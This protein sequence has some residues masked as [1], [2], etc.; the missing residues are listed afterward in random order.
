GPHARVYK[1]TDGGAT[2]NML[3]GGL[4]SGVMGRTGLAISQ[5]NPDKVYAIFMDSLS[6]PGGLYKTT[7]G[8]QSWTSINVVALEDACGDFGWYFSKIRLDPTND[9]DV[10]FLAILLWR[11]PPGNN[12]WQPA[13]NSHADIHD[14]VFAPTGKRY[15][16][17]DGG[18]Y[19]NTPGQM[20]WFKSNNLP[21]TQFYRTNYNPHEPDFYFAGAQDNGIR[22]G[23]AGVYNGWSSLFSADGFRCMFHPT[24]PNTFWIE[25]QNGEIH[26]TIDG[27]ANWAFGSPCLG[28]SDRCNWDL[29]YL[30]SVHNPNRLFAGTYRVYFSDNGGGWGPISNDLTDGV[31]FGPR[32]H[33]I[34]TLD[35]SPVLAE[36]LVAG[37][38]DGNVWR[39]EPTGNWTNISAGLPDR[40]V[41]ATICSPTL[42]N[43]IFVT[44][45]GFRNNEY[46]PHIHRSDNNGQ[47]W[48]DISGNLP[49]MPVNDV[50][51]LPG[52]ADSVLFAATDAGVYVSRSS[53][54][55][56]QRLG[57][58]MPFVP[59]FDLERNPVKK[60]LIAATFARGLWTF[61]LD[62]VF[63]L[64]PPPPSATVAV[65]GTIQTETGSGIDLVRVCTQPLIHTEANG[66]YTIY[67]DAPGLSDGVHPLRNN[68][69]LNGVSTFDLVLIN[70]HIL[71][72]EPLSSPFK[73]IAA[74]ANN[75]RSITTFDIVALRKLILGI[76]T[77]LANTTSWRFIPKDYSFPN[78]LN[79][80]A[81]V[82]PEGKT[83]VLPSQPPS[84]PQLLD[85][86]G[87]KVGDVNENAVP[88][89]GAVAE[90]RS[91]GAWRL[92][93]RDHFFATGDGVTLPVEANWTGIAGVQFSLHYDP[94]VLEPLRIEP[95]ADGLRPDH[96]A[97]RP[98]G[99]SCVT[100]C[101]EQ[102]RAETGAGTTTLFRIHFRAKT[103]GS[104][105]QSIQLRS[106]PT[107]ALAFRADATVFSPQLQW[108][109]EE[110]NN[111]LELRFSP[112]P[113]GA[114][115]TVLNWSGKQQA[116]A[117]L[118]VYDAAG[119]IVFQQNLD[120]TEW[121]L[122][123]GCFTQKGVYW[124]TVRQGA[125]KRSGKLVF[126]GN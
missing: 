52:H 6:T 14:L 93:V 12:G 11:K 74:D 32:F 27:G 43:R 25:T 18:V 55:Q 99:Q 88:A 94:E 108:A 31:I 67:S 46:Q 23:N 76:D 96:F 20:A 63:T 7:D 98:G 1:S 90:Y 61:P 89:A 30:L 116:P 95:L 126:V 28:T 40:Y 105:R 107:P 34:S 54:Q 102:A 59:V 3:G 114:E 117:Q 58:S 87:V 119:K 97:L 49:N 33:S 82:F 113:F 120:S 26:K 112:N 17:S 110:S 2:W 62:S 24:E 10:Y 69:P 35:E 123:A 53:G 103:S 56:W 44:H 22:R 124:Y 81:E 111:P 101:F 51:V 57:V 41:T 66:G 64:P 75:S 42:S 84:Q 16:G 125:E 21:T 80:F 73:M 70:K 115:G 5:Q 39:R 91:G 15:L 100:A 48:T 8:G 92:L 86:T 4:P 85:F 65:S 118:T 79:P 78:P 29:P 9:E 45:S 68:D 50:Y 71:G 104:L 77:A 37:T 19:R 109:M 36:K 13:A 83:I 47:T 121:R 106:L 60:E 72:I 122:P 38:T